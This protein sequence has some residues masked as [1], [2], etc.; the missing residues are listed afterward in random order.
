MDKRKSRRVFR[1]ANNTKQIIKRNNNMLHKYHVHKNTLVHFNYKI[2]FTQ[3]PHKTLPKTNI[4]QKPKKIQFTL[5]TKSDSN[6]KK[7]F[8]PL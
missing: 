7:K 6:F 4:T 1:M 3:T 2:T 8:S 5:I